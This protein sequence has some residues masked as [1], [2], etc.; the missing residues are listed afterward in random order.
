[1]SDNF[2]WLEDIGV[3][4]D[5]G[6]GTFALVPKFLNNVGVKLVE[7]LRDNLK[8]HNASGDLSSSI[9]FE[10][11]DLGNGVYK[12]QLFIL[13]YYTYVDKGVKGKKF[14]HSESANSPYQY[15][16]KYPPLSAISKWVGIKGIGM[17]VNATSKKGLTYKKK[18]KLERDPLQQLLRTMQ[19]MIYSRGVKATNFYSSVINK[20]M[21]EGIFKSL[22]GLGDK[23]MVEVFDFTK[24]LNK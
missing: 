21:E 16:D 8:D 14:T 19:Y 6:K 2:N 10:I 7:E 22:E 9:D 12:F 24:S 17:T 15:K 4:A 18:I 20:P 3:K 11:T 5:E 23:I 1:M 13:P